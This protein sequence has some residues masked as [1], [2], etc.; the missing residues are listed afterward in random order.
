MMQKLEASFA[1]GISDLKR[2][3]SEVLRN[4]GGEPVAVLNHNRVMAYLLPAATWEAMVERL[5]D[6]EL[7]SIIAERAAETPVPVTLDDL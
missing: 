7:A 3:P 6:M 1:I 5:D 2:N 4:A